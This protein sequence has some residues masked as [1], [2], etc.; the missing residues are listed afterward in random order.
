MCWA[1]IRVLPFNMTLLVGGSLIVSPA[2]ETKPR[3]SPSHDPSKLQK[4]DPRASRPRLAGSCPAGR[5]L[6]PTDA[7][8]TASA[9]ANASCRLADA[10]GG[11]SCS[12][13]WCGR[14][15]C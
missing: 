6:T 2:H 14:G 3:E 5:T 8:E 10:P 11:N 7:R 15:G 4:W 13:P 12:F 9:R 1:V